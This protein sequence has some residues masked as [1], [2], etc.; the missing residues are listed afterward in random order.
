MQCAPLYDPI[1][2]VVY[3]GSNDGAFYKVA[4]KDGKLRWRFMSNAEVSRRPI[5]QNG[6]LYVVNANDTLLALEPDTGKV[7][8]SQ[9]RSPATGME[10]RGLRWARAVPRQGVHRLQ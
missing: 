6:L 8:W 3:F 2:D 5:L 9:H 7:R 1:E 4:A 10:S